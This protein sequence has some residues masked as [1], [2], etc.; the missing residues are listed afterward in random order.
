[1][2]FLKALPTEDMIK[3]YEAAF[4]QAN[5]KHIDQALIMMRRASLLI[6][7]LEA[8][9]ANYDLSLLRFL[10]LIVLDR[11]PSRSRL[12]ISEIR[13]RID[14]SKPVMTRTLNSLE[15]A[16]YIESKNSE[17]DRRNKFIQLSATGE[18]KLNQVL[19]GY[20]ELI[21]KFMKDEKHEV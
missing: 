12:T 5:A 4:P 2:F 13:D 19:P 14:V 17:H 20:F 7:D 3:R 15:D 16:S 21:S 10:I 1:M 6:R 8:Y 18:D 9:F 11:E